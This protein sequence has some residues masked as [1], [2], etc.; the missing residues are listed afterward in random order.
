MLQEIKSEGPPAIKL[1]DTN[2]KLYHSVATVFAHVSKDPITILKDTGKNL[3]QKQNVLVAH[4]TKPPSAALNPDQSYWESFTDL[5]MMDAEVF[6]RNYER[7]IG[8]HDFEYRKSGQVR[9]RRMDEN[10]AI[11]IGGGGNGNGADNTGAIGIIESGNAGDYIVE[12][13]AGDQWVEEG[14]AFDSTYVEVPSTDA[15]ATARHQ[16]N[17]SITH[18]TNDN[19]HN[20]EVHIKLVGMGG[21][22]LIESTDS[23]HPHE[24]TNV[25]TKPTQ[26]LRDDPRPQSSLPLTQ[27]VPMSALASTTRPLSQSSASSSAVLAARLSNTPP[28]IEQSASANNNKPRARTISIHPHSHQP[29]SPTNDTQPILPLKSSYTDS[30]AP[31]AGNTPVSTLGD[32]VRA[33]PAPSP[34]HKKIVIT[35]RAAVGDLST[36]TG[37]T[38]SPPAATTPPI[39]LTP[40]TPIVDR[41]DSPTRRLIVTR[42][43]SAD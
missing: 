11:R 31:L 4:S 10:F 25:K 28:S 19:A 5:H 22:S 7:V 15:T 18:I 42:T 9:A 40:I 32:S 39:A 12:N 35:K 43:S 41:E 23:P 6:A 17:E 20:G 3:G 27:T 2:S 38:P 8:G 16:S 29:L 14:K 13:S 26:S 37:V 30:I 1:D 24:S 36:L 21:G 33:A 34:S